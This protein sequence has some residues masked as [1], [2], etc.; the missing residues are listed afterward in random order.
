MPP[1][2]H[3][4]NYYTDSNRINKNTQKQTKKIT[5]GTKRPKILQ[6]RWQQK[7][8]EQPVLQIP[9]WIPIKYKDTDR[10]PTQRGQEQVQGQTLLLHLL[11]P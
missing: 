6:L 10:E 1:S 7:Q 4:K 5:R 2:H 9:L 8:Q 11:T 3:K